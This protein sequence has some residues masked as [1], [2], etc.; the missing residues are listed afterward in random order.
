M[1]ITIHTLSINQEIN[2][3]V[4]LAKMSVMTTTT[5]NIG[6]TTVVSF[7]RSHFIGMLYDDVNH[8]NNMFYDVADES[9]ET[10]F[11]HKCINN[12]EN[13]V[14]TLTCQN[15]K[16]CDFTICIDKEETRRHGI[17]GYKYKINAKVDYFTEFDGELE[18]IMKQKYEGELLTMI[19]WLQREC[20]EHDEEMLE[21]EC[22][23]L[24]HDYEDGRC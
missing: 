20:D 7:D 4:Q 15:R 24:Q 3:P 5:V 1:Y 6:E 17:D 10:E 9:Y 12:N 11:G 18:M 22:L 13:M 2:L 8:I 14:W 16:M 23:E 19:Q 21:N